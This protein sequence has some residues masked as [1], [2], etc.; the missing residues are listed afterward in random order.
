MEDFCAATRRT[1][2]IDLDQ[3]KYFEIADRNDLSWSS[4]LNAYFEL[5]ERYFDSDRFDEF[6]RK[7]L[8]HIDEVANEYFTS[9]EFDDLLVRTVRESFPQHEHDHFTGHYRGLMNQWARAPQGMLA[10]A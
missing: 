9:K 7:N 4:K 5:S 8:S 10:K 3:R 2:A 6:C 1:M